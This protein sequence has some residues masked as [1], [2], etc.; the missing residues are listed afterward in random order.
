MLRKT[1]FSISYGSYPYRFARAGLEAIETIRNREQLDS[2]YLF[3]VIQGEFEARLN[4]PQAAI[5]Y[6]RK[7]LQLVTMKSEKR[8]IAKKIQD[9]EDVYPSGREYFSRSLP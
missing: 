2:Y 8:F 1:K 6:F 9:L 4:H 7:S 5:K 3:Y